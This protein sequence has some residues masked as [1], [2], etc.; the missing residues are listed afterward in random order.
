MQDNLERLSYRDLA[1]RLGISPDAARMKAKRK[2]KAGLWRIIPGNHPSE[3]VLIEMPAADLSGSPER[4]GGEQ[5]KCIAPERSPRTVAPERANASG[6]LMLES[7]LQAQRRIADLTDVLI[8][9]QNVMLK[10]QEAHRRDGMELAAAETRELGTKAE[11]ERALADV[12]ML[13][14]QLRLLMERE[15][16][17]WWRK[18]F[19]A[20][21]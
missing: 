6:E 12:E 20:S 16:R 18:I 9:A 15:R 5:P 1:D 21:E 2:V 11:L 7:L 10:V 17:P 19:G 14:D 3:R 4:V 8:Q 13:R